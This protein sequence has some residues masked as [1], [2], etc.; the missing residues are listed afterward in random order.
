LENR[1]DGTREPYGFGIYT[2][3]RGLKLEK[4][5]PQMTWE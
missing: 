2:V 3:T 4:R 1:K 5:I